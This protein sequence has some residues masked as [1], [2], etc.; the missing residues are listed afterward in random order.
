MGIKVERT[1]ANLECCQ[2]V[3]GRLAYS[4]Y[5]SGI[6]G[7]A[8]LTNII[9]SLLKYFPCVCWKIQT[10]NGCVSALI[11]N[12][13]I[14]HNMVHNKIDYSTIYFRTK[15]NNFSKMYCVPIT[16]RYKT[17]RVQYID[18]HTSLTW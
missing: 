16:I 2:N 9:T 18:R 8:S 12:Y 10:V 3:T 15:F 17:Q 5:N 1:H 11:Y 13:V 6:T 14:F 7:E 4:Y